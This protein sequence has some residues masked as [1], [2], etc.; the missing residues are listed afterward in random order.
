[1]TSNSYHITHAG[2][3]LFRFHHY[4]VRITS[5]C[6]VFYSCNSYLVHVLQV[7]SYS[8]QT[9]TYT[10][11]SQNIS[12]SYQIHT[13]SYQT[14]TNTYQ[15]WTLV[16]SRYRSHQI[17]IPGSYRFKTYPK[18]NRFIGLYHIHIQTYTYSCQGIRSVSFTC[19]MTFSG[20]R[21]CSWSCHLHNYV[22]LYLM[23]FNRILTSPIG[24]QSL[25]RGTHRYSQSGTEFLS[26][27]LFIIH[28]YMVYVP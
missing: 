19:V 18:I 11:A 12:R 16:H 20:F 8:E 26:L 23:N 1:M 27:L 5:M 25:Y 2:F 28:I 3:I 22:Y 17:N 13:G 15:I 9:Y 21:S 14:Y 7:R 10:M 24:V 6:H 4:H